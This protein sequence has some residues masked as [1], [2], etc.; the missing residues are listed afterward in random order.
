GADVTGNEEFL[1][2]IPSSE[3]PRSAEYPYR[4]QIVGPGCALGMLPRSR[5]A[6]R[7]MRPLRFTDE[8][9]DECYSASDQPLAHCALYIHTA[10]RRRETARDRQTATAR[11]H[12]YAR[13]LARRSGHGSGR[14]A[15][16]PDHLL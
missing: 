4:K 13:R 15:D 1:L 3:R 7:V 2:C 12:R 16:L 5:D 14:G 6:T 8:I 9:R 11:D 10:S